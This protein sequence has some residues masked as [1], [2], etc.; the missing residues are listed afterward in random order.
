MWYLLNFGILLYVEGNGV[1]EISSM[2]FVLLFS[3]SVLC[4]VYLAA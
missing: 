2:G 3:I 4:F 1:W